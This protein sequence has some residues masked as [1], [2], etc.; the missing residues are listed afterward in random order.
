MADQTQ[1]ET[2]QDEMNTTDHSPEAAQFG[3]SDGD[4]ESRSVV[5][6]K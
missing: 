4:S 5:M 2:T 3:S 6:Q 1:T